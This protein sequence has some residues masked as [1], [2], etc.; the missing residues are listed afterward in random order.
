M[1]IRYEIMCVLQNEM[2]AIEIENKLFMFMEDILGI[3][4]AI[5]VMKAD[6]EQ[7]IL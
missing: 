4:C 3:D 2:E 7:E 1:N 5:S 6:E